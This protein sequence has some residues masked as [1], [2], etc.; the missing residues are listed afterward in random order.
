MDFLLFV[1]AIGVFIVSGL[2][3]LN[4]MEKEGGADFGIGVIS[5]ISFML[6]LGIVSLQ[7]FFYSIL[8][9]PFSFFSIALPWIAL[10]AFSFLSSEWRDSF[11]S[12][13]KGSDLTRWRNTTWYE[14]IL[15]LI[16]VSQ[17][18][19]V[20]VYALLMPV[21]GWD[22]LEIWFF[23]ARGFFGEKK[24]SVSF[25]LNNPAAKPD[26]PLLIPLSIAWIY[27]SIGKI[28]EHLAKILY[29]LQYV[30]LLII[31]L[32]LLKKISSRKNALLFT[33]LLSLTPVL[34]IH[35]GGL[36]VSL[37][38]LY[39]GDFVGYADITL[40]IYFMSSCGFLYLYT[41]NQT[42]L[43]L[44]I[45]VLFLGMGA[46]TKNEGLT[47]AFIGICLTAACLSKKQRHRL[48]VL[49]G[50]LC[51]IVAPWL[52]YKMYFNITSGG[53]TD[54]IH[55]AIIRNN[56][57]RLPFILKNMGVH[58]FGDIALF[59]FTSYAYVAASIINWRVFFRR[60][61]LLLNLMLLSQFA[62]YIFIYMIS[63]YDIAWHLNTSFDRLILHLTPLAMLITATNVWQ[64]FESDKVQSDAV[65]I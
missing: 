58:M 27:T 28:N 5:A 18:V 29:P 40:S 21:N 47:F 37:G 11:F 57:N 33:T 20:F 8:S 36:P 42:R 43:F 65:K 55:F 2:I 32:H 1:A 7:M 49:A 30:S 26:Y 38:R 48:P 41:L 22:A 53:Y 61:L 60:P 51:A 25:F 19:Y 12:R 3:T 54:N 15:L 52:I 24:V 17:I 4:F 64:K 63:P 10:T 14:G 50:I 56:I 45:A 16:M 31:F 39:S 23:K 59:N 6:G 46:W 34:L 9:I 44:I 62:I 13:L 35:A